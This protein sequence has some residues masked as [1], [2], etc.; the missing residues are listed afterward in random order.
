MNQRWGTA[1]P[2][3]IRDR[4][5][6]AARLRAYGIYACR[7]AD[8]RVFYTKVSGT[9]EIYTVAD[10][11]GQLRNMIVGRISDTFASAQ[12]AFL[13]MAA[14]QVALSEKIAGQMKPAFAELGLAL[15]TFVVR[16][17]RYRRTPENSRSA[18][19]HGHGRRHGTVYAVPDGAVAADCRG[20]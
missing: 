8:P 6:G 14:N 10:I 19:W 11:D 4:E 2:V 5:F 1:T 18:D 3:T 9:R 7:V 17:S 13:D 20:Q 16:I 12:I 15:E